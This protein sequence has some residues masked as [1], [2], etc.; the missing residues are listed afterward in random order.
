MN[1]FCFTTKRGMGGLVPSHFTKA[2]CAV[3]IYAARLN[4]TLSPLP[5]CG[6]SGT[7]HIRY[8]KCVINLTINACP[9]RL[10]SNIIFYGRGVFHIRPL[11]RL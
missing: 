11:E 5:N 2:E 9:Y 7:Q 4:C 8:A 1:C 3:E 10:T 6:Q